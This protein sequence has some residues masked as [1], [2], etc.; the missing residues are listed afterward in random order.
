MSL[1]EGD[2]KAVDLGLGVLWADR[3]VDSF[4][5]VS[6]GGYYSWGDLYPW[7]SEYN[8]YFSVPLGQGMSLRHLS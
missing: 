2:P 8:Y 6:F 5:P 4:L 3:N 1:T 7:K